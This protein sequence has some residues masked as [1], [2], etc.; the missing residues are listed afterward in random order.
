MVSRLDALGEGV[1]HAIGVGGRD[2]SEAVGGLMALQA[3]DA[4]A[5]DRATQAIVLISKPPASVG[6]RASHDKMAT[7]DK[8]IVVCCIGA[9]PGATAANRL[10]W[11]ETLDQAADA[12]VALLAGRA[13]QVARFQ[14]RRA[15]AAQW[16]RLDRREA[17]AGRQILGL[18]TGGTLAYETGHLLQQALGADHPHRILDLGDDEYTIGRPQ[19]MIDPRVRTDMIVKAGGDAAVGVMLLDLVLGLGANE[20]PAEWLV[21]AVREARG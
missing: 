6:A 16:A 15:T 10:V 9:A 4:L 17:F 13:W 8:P 3:L 2:L 20:N 21:S 7:I 14:R 11:V 19:P 12:V 18:Y 1:S 5:D